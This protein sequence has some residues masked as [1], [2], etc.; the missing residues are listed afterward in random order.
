MRTITAA[1]DRLLSLT[2]RSEH[3]RVLI[4]RD[5]T[6]NFVDV[7]DLSDY[8]WIKSV[9]WGE[10]IDRPVASATV[11]LVRENYDLSLAPLDAASK[12]N[13]AAQLIE[14]HRLI[15]IETAVLPM[16]AIPA[17]ADFELMFEGRID[18]IQWG[19]LGSKIV[20]TCRDL[21]GDLQSEFIEIQTQH[22]FTDQLNV[23]IQDIL[24]THASSPPTLLVASTP[25]FAI[26]TYLQQ[27]QPIMK[28]IRTLGLLIGFDVR[29]RFDNAGGDHRL[30]LI[31]PDRAPSS[32]D[33][34]FGPDDYDDLP[35][36]SINS[37]NIRN[38]I[39][40]IYT[41]SGTGVKTIIESSDAASI[42]RFGRRFMEITEG[43]ASVITGSAAATRL[44]DAALAE[45]KDPELES[46]SRQDYFSKIQLM[47][48]Y[49]WLANNIHYDTDQ[50]LAVTG[51]QHTAS[52]SGATVSIKTEMQLRGKPSVGK[53][54]WLA[55]DGGRPGVASAT[56]TTGPAKPGISCSTGV[57]SITI[58]IDE[59]AELDW[60]TTEIYLDTS[61]IPATTFPTKPSQSLKVASGRRSRFDITGL[62]PGVQVFV[63][64]LVIDVKGNFIETTDL[65]IDVPEKV[66]AFHENEETWRQ[67]LIG[68]PQFGQQ[69]RDAATFEPDG[70]T[71][72]TGAWGAGN[73]V[74]DEAVSQSGCA[75]VK[76]PA[77]GSS[78]TIE[79]VSDFIPIEGD[80]ILSGSFL[81]RK[82]AADANT[83]LEI[84]LDFYQ[85]DKTTLVESVS[86]GTDT[87]DTGADFLKVPT[88]WIRVDNDSRY[89]QARIRSVVVTSGTAN[90]YVD[91][92]RTTKALG[93]FRAE[94]SGDEV[95][96]A[97]AT[98][99]V[100]FDTEIFD[101]GEIYD[102]PN[103][104]ADFAFDGISS[105]S[106][107]V[108]MRGLTT[109]EFFAIGIRRNGVSKGTSPIVFGRG[110]LLVRTTVTASFDI[111]KGDLI[112]V[113]LTHSGPTTGGVDIVSGPSDSY[114]SGN[115][116]TRED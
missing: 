100:P 111:V 30:T 11:T 16:D 33:R 4:D 25:S 31:E 35:N 109:T 74:R 81:F 43:A 62:I 86:I 7:S 70:W 13:Q 116:I 17:D 52:V 27:K 53:K 48:F 88:E 101:R 22:G 60:A 19:G 61:T 69:T 56:D 29:Y 42:T 110:S 79:M 72:T 58:R 114:F 80:D 94:M 87:T 3:L 65:I 44:A 37:I 9:R 113:V 66:G 39:R 78:R 107:T 45:L 77:I 98:V 99:T 18:K 90:I 89:F 21:G 71:V 82:D 50:E 105:F 91:S 64:A 104:E 2:N 85:G 26:D 15:K 6:S 57:G 40:V 46:S 12:F 47:D 23:V 8:D 102:T 67:N 84:F 63:R 49:R 59:P 14:I 93:A 68:N 51:Y 112:N 103:K 38:V 96:L 41:D 83:S 106:A 73:V 92:V 108:S 76:F 1:E 32:V 5:G 55:L 28:A 24:D 97:F 34:T 75:S 20:L 54:R 115:N 10:N 36:V 95:D